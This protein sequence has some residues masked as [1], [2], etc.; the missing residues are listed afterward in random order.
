MGQWT[1]KQRKPA[2]PDAPMLEGKEIADPETIMSLYQLGDFKYQFVMSE[3]RRGHIQGCN[4]PAG[5][6]WLM[7]ELRSGCR[8]IV[9]DPAMQ[10]AS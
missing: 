4:N 10:K 8:V 3:G 7:D 5:R 6:D 9:E 2:P 1:N